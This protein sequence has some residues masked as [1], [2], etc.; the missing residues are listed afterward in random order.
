MPRREIA[1]SS[2]LVTPWARCVRS[3]GRHARRVS[4][5]MAIEDAPNAR[6]MDRVRRAIRV[7][8]YSRRTDEAYAV[9]IRRDIAHHQMRNPSKQRDRS[10]LV[11]T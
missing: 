7:R 4:L 9:W 3:L 10:V 11:S 1:E 6:L 5:R 2:T 8:H